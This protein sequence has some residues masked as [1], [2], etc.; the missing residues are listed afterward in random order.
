MNSLY[1]IHEVEVRTLSPPPIKKGSKVQGLM[2]EIEADHG[3][4]SV[5]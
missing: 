4:L 1:A 5:E 2:L 3:V